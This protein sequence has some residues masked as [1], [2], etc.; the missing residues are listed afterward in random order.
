MLIVVGVMMFIVVYVYLLCVELKDG[1]DF[2]NVVMLF[3]LML[4]VV[5]G[6]M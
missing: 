1:G 5:F 3:G 2:V 6:V 4:F